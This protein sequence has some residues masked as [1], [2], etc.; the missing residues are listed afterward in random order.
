MAL[1][2][3]RF[4]EPQRDRRVSRRYVVECPA[5]F[6]M[7]GGDR[8]GTL[9]DL[10]EHG[11]Q[12]ETALAP[13]VGTSGFLRWNGEEH[14]CQVIWS[15]ET[16]CGLRFERPIALAV[17]EASCSRVEVTTLPVAAVTRIPLG[18]RRSGRLALVT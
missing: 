12:L 3:A 13:V 6:I 15:S 16:R 18:Q 5:R 7:G 14:Y 1:S 2:S 11:A 9:S 4:A 17:V 10:S 8:V